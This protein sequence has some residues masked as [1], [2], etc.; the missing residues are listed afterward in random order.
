MTTTST[1]DAKL[2]S[3]RS[4]PDERGHFG[5]TFGTLLPRDAFGIGVS[6]SDEKETRRILEIMHDRHGGSITRFPRSPFYG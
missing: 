2:N 6:G 3:Y 4:G 5:L 1:A